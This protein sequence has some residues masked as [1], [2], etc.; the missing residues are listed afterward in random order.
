MERI[1]SSQNLIIWQIIIW[2][3]TPSSTFDCFFHLHII[4]IIQHTKQIF[5][6][7]WILPQP[8]ETKHFPHVLFE[9]V[10]EIHICSNYENHFNKFLS[11][12]IFRPICQKFIQINVLWSM[13]HLL[14]RVGWFGLD[15]GET[16]IQNNHLCNKLICSIHCVKRT[17]YYP[18]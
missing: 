6:S 3:C 4:K 18:S 1:N 14:N 11:S 2:S 16:L 15:Q 5:H 17:H 13:D 7:I 12:S 8:R 9:F 10:K